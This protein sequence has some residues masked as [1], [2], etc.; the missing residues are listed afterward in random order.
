MDTFL[1]MALNQANRSQDQ[2]KIMSLG[3]FAYLLSY[4]LKV[5][6]TNKWDRIENQLMKTYRYTRLSEDEIRIY[7]SALTY[8]KINGHISTTMDKDYAY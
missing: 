8:L 6:E 2:N 5:A 1:P 7:R 4:M 3:P